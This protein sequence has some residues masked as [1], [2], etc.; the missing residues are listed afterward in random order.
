M[1][2]SDYLET[3][4][5]VKKFGDVRAVDGVSLRIRRGEIHGL[6]GENGS[7][8]STI[9]SMIAGLSAVSEGKML[10][11][12]KD[13]AP[14]NVLD[15]REHGVAMIVQ[16]TGT[17]DY[18]SLAQNIFLG[19]EKRFAKWG[20]V[21]ES[22][23]NEAASEA[24]KRIHLELDVTKP[25]IAFTFETRKLVE[26]AKA[27]YFNPSLFI[28]DETT[29]AL[30]FSG[31]K[32]IQD[33]MRELRQEG[34]A[35]LFISHDIDELIDLCDVLTILRDGKK[36]AEVSKTN[37]EEFNPPFIKKS[38]V[39]R[40]LKDN[41][42]RTD[43]PESSSEDGKAV[44]TADEVSGHGLKQVSFVL[45]RGEILGFG[46]L[47]GS[48]MHEIGKM[49][50][51]MDKPESGKILSFSKDK[52]GALKPRNI[53][54]IKDALACSI[55]YVSKDRDKETLIMAETIKENLTLS[56][57]K[58]LSRGGFVS[59]KK[60]KEFSEKLIASLK[61]KCSSSAQ[62]VMELSGGN[63][64]KVSFSKWIGNQSAILVFDSPTRGVDVGVKA[65]MYQLLESLRGEGYSIVII[66]EELPELIGMSDRILIMKDGG[67]AHEFTRRK[68]LSEQDIIEYMI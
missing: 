55:G 56:A 31:R 17:I 52:A 18:L 40:T 58:K 68:E 25:A 66:S 33:L 13:Y 32:T 51:G 12:G 15:A 7:G 38:M 65:T 29:T 48:G 19:E 14:K 23:M 2:N 60:E 43:Y 34:K 59:P 22:R 4:N 20:F 62:K 50:F 21:S 36:V 46:G 10:L 67:I 26:V 47:S 24:L 61:I 6:I 37:P 16:E 11:E 63:K 49:L 44:L 64:Q 27:L 35:V 45:H 28:V 42:Y 41:Y 9:S 5:L 39:G 3:Q 30:S 53:R 1:T 57:L 54:R 8:K